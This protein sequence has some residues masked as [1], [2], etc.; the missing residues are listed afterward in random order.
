MQDAQEIFNRIAENKEKIKDIRIMLEGVY[1]QDSNY[2]T[3]TEDVNDKKAK[4][5]AI[6]I[7][8]NETCRAEVNQLEALKN[9]VKTDRELLRDILLDKYT[10]G[11]KIELEGKYNQLVLPIFS[12]TFKQE[13]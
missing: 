8:L 13:K 3:I 4:L 10:K 6:R 9:D 5:K 11:E 7:A 2:V 1:M 12:L